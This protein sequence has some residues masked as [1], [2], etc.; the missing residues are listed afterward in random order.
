MLIA[1]NTTKNEYNK[2]HY[3]NNKGAACLSKR[4]VRIQQAKSS[5]TYN[6]LRIHN[7][8]KANHWKMPNT[9]SCYANL[10]NTTTLSIVMSVFWNSLWVHVSIYAGIIHVSSYIIQKR[11]KSNIQQ[12]QITK[13]QETKTK[14][15][16]N[17]KSVNKHMP[18]R[19]WTLKREWDQV[20]QE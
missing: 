15:V 16:T 9:E 13:M 14:S 8:I 2:Q 10:S 19:I 7:N 17:S 6:F 18:F 5:R 20:L 1:N 4:R 12:L 11:T 3:H